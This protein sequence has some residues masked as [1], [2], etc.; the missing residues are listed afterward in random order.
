MSGGKVEEGRKLGE[1]RSRNKAN[2]ANAWNEAMY[3]KYRLLGD[4]EVERLTV[5]WG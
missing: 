2:G 1:K 5:L 3:Q 4:G